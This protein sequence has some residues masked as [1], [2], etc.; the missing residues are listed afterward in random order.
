MDLIEVDSL[1]N[2]VR[3]AVKGWGV[4]RLVLR[5]I[6]TDELAPVLAWTQNNLAARDEELAAVKIILA[7]RDEEIAAVKIILAARD[8]ELAAVKIILAARD[9]VIANLKALLARTQRELDR[10]PRWLRRIA[11]VHARLS[12]LKDNATARYR[13]R[14]AHS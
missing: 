14:S 4:R 3:A 8:E 5:D 9:E 7:A 2:S 6:S 11:N 12:A 10:Q 1:L 13:S